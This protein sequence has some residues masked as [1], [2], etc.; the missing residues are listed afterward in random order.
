MDK[1]TF[2]IQTFG[3]QMNVYDSERIAILLEEQNYR[4]VKTPEE[5]DL[6]FVNTCSVREKPEQKLFS[7]L[8]RWR[9]V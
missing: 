7:A 8:G 9:Q 5:A 1:R 6:I 2:Y 4:R 3:C